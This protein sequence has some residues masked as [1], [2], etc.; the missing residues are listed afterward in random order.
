M[1]T[2]TLALSAVLGMIGTASVVAQTNVYSLNAVGYIN[3]S[4]PPGFS[5]L[6]CPLICTPDNTI[7]TVLNNTTGTFQPNGNNA[8]VYAFTGGTYSASDIAGEYSGGNGG[9][10]GGGTIT[11]NPGQAIFFDNTDPSTTIK[12]T[13]VGTVPQNGS[14][15]MTNNLA[16]GYSL[17]S[18][19]VPVS[20]DL[21]TNSVTGAFFGSLN[22]ADPYPVGGDFI[23]TY[24]PVAGFQ[25][26]VFEPLAVGG[27]TGGPGTGGPGGGDPVTTNVAQ[28]F[29]YYNQS[30]GL[31]QWVENFSINP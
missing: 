16:P 18:S 14:Y 6:S 29:F 2:K 30:G 5:M 24:D 28:G 8:I 4:I 20:G 3:V 17:V 13:F 22:N 12:C 1:R 10:A 23:Y 15:N 19:I 25:Q 11:L 27:W 21:V 31:E 9:W 7:A 26:A